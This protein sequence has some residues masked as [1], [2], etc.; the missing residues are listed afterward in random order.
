MPFTSLVCRN[1]VSQTNMFWLFLIQFSFCWVILWSGATLDSLRTSQTLFLFYLIVPR[2]DK[3]NPVPATDLLPPPCYY[4][5]LPWCLPLSE[6]H[7]L[8]TPATSSRKYVLLLLPI[9]P[10]YSLL[11]NPA[12]PLLLHTTLQ[13]FVDAR[14]STLAHLHCPQPLLMRAPIYPFFFF[15]GPVIYSQ[16]IY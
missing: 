3:K 4:T 12:R 10:V 6:L 5:Q 8:S 7:P 1:A 14:P 13:Q 2:P 11:C 16:K 9:P 15:P